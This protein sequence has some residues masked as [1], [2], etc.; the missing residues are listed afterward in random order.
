LP[1][2]ADPQHFQHVTLSHDPTLPGG[3]YRRKWFYVLTQVKCSREREQTRADAPSRSSL[4]YCPATSEGARNVA[5]ASCRTLSAYVSRT[6]NS[7]T[8]P[9][10]GQLAVS[11][12]DHEA[13]RLCASM[14]AGVRCLVFGQVKNNAGTVHSLFQAGARPVPNRSASGLRWLPFRG[15]PN[16]SIQEPCAIESAPPRRM[17][18]TGRDLPI[19]HLPRR[20]MTKPT[21]KESS[22]IAQPWPVHLRKPGEQK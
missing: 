20:V 1:T 19:T 22:I 18:P 14:P 15:N 7:W 11:V 3:S 12:L 10:S 5:E 6:T 8:S 9:Q 21:P 13:R 2:S 16:R 4:R 17:V